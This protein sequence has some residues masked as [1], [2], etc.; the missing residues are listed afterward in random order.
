MGARTPAFGAEFIRIMAAKPPRGRG[1]ESIARAAS[2][3]LHAADSIIGNN[4]L[5]LGA[6]AMEARKLILSMAGSKKAVE[7][8]GEKESAVAV[9]H[10][11]RAA[12]MLI[13]G[14]KSP[15]EVRETVASPG[16]ITALG[17]QKFASIGIQGLQ[18][19]VDGMLEA[20]FQRRK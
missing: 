13:M 5:N 16:G 18:E 4:G 19:V 10:A 12:S 11:F 6:G 9:A 14:G 1:S 3:F 8:Y 2:E 17:L 7:L 20:V 15:E